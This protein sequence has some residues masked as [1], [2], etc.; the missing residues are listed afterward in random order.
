[1]NFGFEHDVFLFVYCPIDCR[2]VKLEVREQ[3]VLLLIITGVRS[4]LGPSMQRARVD[5]R[6]LA[7]SHEELGTWALQVYVHKGGDMELA[8][9]VGDNFEEAI[10]RL[11]KV[12]VPVFT[13]DCSGLQQDIFYHFSYDF[14]FDISKN[15]LKQWG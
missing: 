1:M 2:G 6:I 15:F 7:V 13:G 3:E 5:R 11:F 10:V 4:L 12:T 14:S 9:F 8:V